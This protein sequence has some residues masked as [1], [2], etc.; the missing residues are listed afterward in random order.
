MLSEKLKEETKTNHQ[1]LEK[2][3]IGRLKA[4][5]SV[6]EYT[7]LL[8]LFY[9]YFGGLET[10][11]NSVIDINQL[12]DSN[13]RRKTQAIADDI[14]ALDGTVPEKATG[15]A[16]PHISSHLEAIGALY[17]IEGSTL[18]GTIISKMMQKQLGLAD[19]GLSFFLGYGEQTEAMWDKFK[20]TLDQ[21]AQNPEQEAVIIAA[22]N[23]TFL[24]FGEWFKAHS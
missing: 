2:E 9:G 14:N 22:A 7:S 8:G 20:D 23:Q 13:Q 11:I 15:D 6:Q 3:L 19:N 16:L 5:G 21:Q 10:S 4:V 1:I 17:V 24:K 18:G 12:P